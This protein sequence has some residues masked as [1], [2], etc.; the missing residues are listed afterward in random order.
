MAMKY[1]ALLFI[2]LF[3]LVGCAGRAQLNSNIL[4]EFFGMWLTCIRSD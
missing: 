2:V 1:L 3:S 4:L